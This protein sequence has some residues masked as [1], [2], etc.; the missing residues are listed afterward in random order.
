VVIGRRAFQ[1]ILKHGK[2]LDSG[3]EIEQVRR[4]STRIAEAINIEP[5]QRE[6]N[7]QVAEDQFEWDY[8]VIEDDQVNAFCLPGGKI[9]V[10]TGLMKIIENDDQLA[11][12]LAH[13]V[14][15]VL[16]HHVSERVAR[17]RSVGHGLLSL[18]YNREQESEADH[19]GVF[20]MTFAG[21]DPDQA[22]DFWRQMRSSQRSGLHLP[23]ILSDHPSDDRRVKQL[24]SW[25]T[26][27]KAGKA[28]YESG[29]IAPR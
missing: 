6:I 1:E 22:L 19:I 4:V 26:A 20:L 3:P 13:E 10:L 7:F 16:V 11:T 2:V 21:Y 18:A 17:E 24:Q 25:V 29:R 8:A 27:A 9:V 14:A 28:A 23:E 5:L 12:V 15:H